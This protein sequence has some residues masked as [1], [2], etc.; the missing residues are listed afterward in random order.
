MRRLISD[1]EYLQ[2]LYERKAIWQSPVEVPIESFRHWSDYI[3]RVLQMDE[4]VVLNPTYSQL[5]SH[6]CDTDDEDKAD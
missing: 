4:Y 2:L 3:Q 1:P 6:H 5:S